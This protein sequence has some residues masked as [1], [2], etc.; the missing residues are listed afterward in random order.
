[1]FFLMGDSM[2]SSAV[3]VKAEARLARAY[4]VETYDTGTLIAETG[5]GIELLFVG[6]HAVEKTVDPCFR[7]EFEKGYIELKPGAD[8]IVVKMTD[9]SELSYPSPDSDHQ[10][11]KLFAAIDNVIKP[12]NAF[13]SVEAAMTQLRLTAEIERTGTKIFVFPDSGI[14]KTDKRIFVNGL[15]DTLA[16]CY[17]NFTLMPYDQQ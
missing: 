16:E 10:F 6:S 13:C 7:I 4:P 2:E 8:R 9:E 15:D 1:M 3:F 14:T 11:K 17:R 5:S 12:G